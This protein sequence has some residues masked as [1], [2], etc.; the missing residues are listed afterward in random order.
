MR[1]FTTSLVLAVAVTAATAGSAGA[2]TAS[3]A[4]LGNP[5]L[6]TLLPGNDTESFLQKVGPDGTTTLLWINESDDL[7]MVRIAP[8]GKYGTPVTVNLLPNDTSAGG[9]GFTL[10]KNGAGVI[11]WKDTTI[12]GSTVKLRRF[13]K[14]G[15]LA[16]TAATVTTGTP[17]NLGTPS[18]ALASDGFATVVWHEGSTTRVIARRLAPDNSVRGSYTDLC[19]SDS[20]KCENPHVVGTGGGVSTIV[21]E[22]SLNGSGELKLRT[23]QINAGDMVTFAPTLSDACSPCSKAVSPAAD[24]SFGQLQIEQS[25]GGGVF[26]AWSDTR[27]ETTT[28]MMPDPGNPAVMIPM[29]GPPIFHKALYARKIG[30][31]GQPVG[32]VQTLRGDIASVSEPALAVNSADNAIVTWVENPGGT[33]VQVFYRRIS[34]SGTMASAKFVDNSADSLR[35]SARLASNGTAT[36]AWL[37]TAGDVNWINVPKTDSI[38]RFTKISGNRST[39]NAQ[40]PVLASGKDGTVIATWLNGSDAARRFVSQVNA[41]APTLATL[42]FQGRFKSRQRSG[43]IRINSSKFGTAVVTIAPASRATKF[44]TR[45]TRVAVP[46]GATVVKFNTSGL[47]RGKY[48]VTVQLVDLAGLKVAKSAKLLVTS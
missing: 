47:V 28:I 12:S 33:P 21:W 41:S 6:G 7:R 20:V 40:G 35:S 1:R 18:V 3:S 39:G 32:T 30:T 43:Q 26:A 17:A 16:A 15:K 8:N 11:V 44:R 5:A 38:G 27:I 29:P 46:S 36:I 19:K 10:D 37:K 42:K 31:N 2:A 48:T 45:V 34:S 24:G 23:N 25:S 13:D 4:W 14:K 22:E 9:F